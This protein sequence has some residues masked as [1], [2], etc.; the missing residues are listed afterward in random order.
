MKEK[1]EQ[2]K[3]DQI[4]VNVTSGAFPLKLWKEWDAD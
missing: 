3:N 1:E 4:T 2:K